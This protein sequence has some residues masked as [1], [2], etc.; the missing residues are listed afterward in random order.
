MVSL[1]SRV[2]RAKRSTRASVLESWTA[3]LAWASSPMTLAEVSR[4]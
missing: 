4:S 3:S 1:L 2:A